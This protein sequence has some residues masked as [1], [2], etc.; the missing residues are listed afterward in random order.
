MSLTVILAMI[1]NALT[2]LASPGGLSALNRLV[3][4]NNIT[5]EALAALAAG[6]PLP[7]PP[8]LGLTYMTDEAKSL[9]EE[10]ILKAAIMRAAPVPKP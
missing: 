4:E 8:T 10:I 2:I 3:G 6:A 1:S 5:P 7:G 9:L